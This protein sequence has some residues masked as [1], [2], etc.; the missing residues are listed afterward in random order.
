[1]AVGVSKTS[2]VNLAL[3]NLRQDAVVENVDTEQSQEAVVARTW[4]DPAR[5]QALSDYDWSF[6]RKRLTLATHADDAPEEEWAYRYQ[7]PADCLAPRR[8]VHPIGVKE[9]AV[10][11]DT[12]TSSGT[13]SIVTNQEDACLVYTYDLVDATQFSPHFVTALSFLLA[14]YMAGPLTARDKIKLEM[15]QSYNLMVELA[16]VHNFNQAVDRE[17]RDPSW[18]RN[19]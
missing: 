17:P 4:Y 6:A 19:R 15:I 18:I 12:E 16:G 8:I 1:M 9:N 2:I 13:L 5:R 7:Y 3:S 11:F 10:P 14:W